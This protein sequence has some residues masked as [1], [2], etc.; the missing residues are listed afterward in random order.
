MTWIMEIHHERIVMRDIKYLAMIDLRRYVPRQRGDIFVLAKSVHPESIQISE[1]RI[2][3]VY[4]SS[5]ME[6]E[7]FYKQLP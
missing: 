5:I 6:G 1:R 4:F 3:Y 2:M 7:K